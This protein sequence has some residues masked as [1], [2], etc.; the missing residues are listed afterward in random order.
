[1]ESQRLRGVLGG[2]RGAW[3]TRI[4]AFFW[5][6]PGTQLGTAKHC[7]LLS[8]RAELLMALCAY[9][10]PCSHST[11]KMPAHARD[12]DNWDDPFR[13]KTEHPV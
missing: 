10:G 2:W 5:E 6:L 7:P 8:G 11:S 3:Q 4:R 12:K 9:L 13:N 1:M